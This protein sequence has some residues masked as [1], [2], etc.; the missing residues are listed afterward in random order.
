MSTLR[1]FLADKVRQ[2]DH[3]AGRQKRDEWVQ[4]LQSLQSSLRTWLRQADPNGLLHV[5][6]FDVE[7]IEEG[8]GYYAAPGLEIRF[9]GDKIR[10]VPVGR[11]VMAPVSM[12]PLADFVQGRVD[13]ADGFDKRILYRVVK[14]DEETWHIASASRKPSVPL[15]Q[16]SFEQMIRELLS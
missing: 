8:I 4:A 5:G 9:M 11:G 10:V 6:V 2:A 12:G 15:T 3:P 16:E 7:R 14:D 1:E 13:V